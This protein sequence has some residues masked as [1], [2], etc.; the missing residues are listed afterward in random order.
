MKILLN[1]SSHHHHWWFPR[2]W[3]FSSAALHTLMIGSEFL[4][5]FIFIFLYMKK[6]E[7]NSLNF[8]SSFRYTVVQRAPQSS[9]IRKSYRN[10]LLIYLTKYCASERNQNKFQILFSKRLTSSIKLTHLPTFLFFVVVVVVVFRSSK[11]KKT[12]W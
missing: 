6:Y 10:D 2:W 12:F 11:K 1:F 5:T 8:P 3:W 9:Q 4:S 7:K